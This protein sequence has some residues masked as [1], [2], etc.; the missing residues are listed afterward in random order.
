MFDLLLEDYG[1]LNRIESS[2]INKNYRSSSSN[3][4]G[5]IDIRNSTITNNSKIVVDRINPHTFSHAFEMLDSDDTIGAIVFRA[6]GRQLCLATKEKDLY[7][8]AWGDSYVITF[9]DYSLYQ[10]DMQYGYA[11]GV[12]SFAKEAQA[13]TAVSRCVKA[14]FEKAPEGTRKKWDAL[15]I[16]KDPSVGEKRLNRIENKKG[17]VPTPSQKI[18][19]KEYIEKLNDDFKERCKNYLDNVRQDTTNKKEVIDYLMNR[20]NIQKLKFR[21]SIY[22]KIDSSTNLLGSNFNIRYQKNIDQEARD[23]PEFLWLL[24]SWN[25]FLP[26][27]KEIY[28][29]NERWGDDKKPLDTLR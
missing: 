27:I 24:F 16:Y 21:G 2:L 9:S 26:Y 11:G 28:Y 3:D 10:L 25:G 6:Y 7:G 23:N 19:Y 5:K 17:A 15:I 13:K 20:S 29:G 22:E 12:K 14:F 8:S 1:N 4:T 18:A